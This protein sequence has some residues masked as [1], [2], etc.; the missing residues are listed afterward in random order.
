M[1][2]KFQNLHYIKFNQN[3]LKLVIFI[4]LLF[5]NNTNMLLQI[6]YLFC[7]AH[8]INEINIIYLFLVKCKRIIYTILADKLY[9]MIYR[10]D[11][12]EIK[13]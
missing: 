10:F 9:K 3:I 12:R 8:A 7:F 1:T 2:N 6:N 4:N 5:A 11:I 13:M